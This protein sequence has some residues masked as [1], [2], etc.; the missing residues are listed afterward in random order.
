MAEEDTDDSILDSI[1]DLLNLP[2]EDTT[3]DKQIVN[4]INAEFSTIQQLGVGPIDEFLIKDNSSMWAEFIQETKYIQMVRNA[5]WIG[6]KLV[7][8]P[9]QT[10]PATAA[11]ERRLNEVQWRL[12]IEADRTKLVPLPV[13]VVI[14]DPEII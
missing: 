6:V 14:V 2:L 7:F 1:K 8:D 3:F 12:R 10:G 11:Y 4:L 13:L 9:P 5:V